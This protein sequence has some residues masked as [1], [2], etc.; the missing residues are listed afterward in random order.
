M[1]ARVTRRVLRVEWR[2]YLA[3]AETFIVFYFSDVLALGVLAV[4]AEVAGGANSPSRW[5]TM[6]SVT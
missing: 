1:I 4:P 3:V 2:R 5:P 6:F